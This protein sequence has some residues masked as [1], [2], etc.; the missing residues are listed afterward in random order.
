MLFDQLLESTVRVQQFT[1][2]LTASRLVKFY[3][4]SLNKVTKLQSLDHILHRIGWILIVLTSFLGAS[5]FLREAFDDW[6][7]NPTGL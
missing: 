2:F 5:L 7:E 4:F 3:I 1:D 6:I